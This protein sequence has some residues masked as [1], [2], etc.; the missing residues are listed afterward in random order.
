MRLGK[1]KL[2]LSDEPRM[3]SGARFGAHVRAAGQLVKGIF[4][5]T[6]VLGS[7]FDLME[8]LRAKGYQLR[9]SNVCRMRS[10]LQSMAFEAV[11][12]SV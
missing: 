11:I 7:I 10:M 5:H 8:F 3:G 12:I 4:V 1:L 6:G 9:F 2:L